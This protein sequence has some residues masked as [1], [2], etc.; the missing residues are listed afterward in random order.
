V[1][2]NQVVAGLA[3][4]GRSFEMENT[5]CTGP[6]CHFTGPLSGATKGACTDT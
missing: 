6:E 3:L 5:S 4:Y 2:A 1:N